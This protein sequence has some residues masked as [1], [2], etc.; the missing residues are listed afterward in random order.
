MYLLVKI[1]LFLK[2]VKNKQKYVEKIHISTKFVLQL[3]VK[4]YKHLL[5]SKNQVLMLFYV[6]IAKCLVI[7][8]TFVVL[9]RIFVGRSY[10][11]CVM[12]SYCYNR[13]N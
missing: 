10:F 5:T 6:I 1:I 7:A 4:Y 12:R 8:I 9:R 13:H 2:I 11:N 3:A